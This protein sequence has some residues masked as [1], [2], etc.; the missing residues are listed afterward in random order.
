MS[1]PLYLFYLF[2]IHDSTRAILPTPVKIVHNIPREGRK[3]IPTTEYNT[4]LSKKKKKTRMD[5]GEREA[6]L[7][8]A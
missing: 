2:Y 6:I 7:T 4:S 8:R 3:H 1:V 5:I